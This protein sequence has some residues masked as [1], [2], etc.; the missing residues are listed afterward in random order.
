MSKYY[1]RGSLPRSSLVYLKGRKGTVLNEEKRQYKLGN[2]AKF[3]FALKAGV[4]EIRRL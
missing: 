4:L 1:K 3:G 2:L